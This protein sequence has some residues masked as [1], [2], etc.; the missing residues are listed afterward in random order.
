MMS[1]IC[2]Q[3]PHG[4]TS[5]CPAVS[6][7]C[8]KRW[9][10][11]PP[12]SP[13]AE[14]VSLLGFLLFGIQDW[15]PYAL[16]PALFFSSNALFFPAS[17]EINLL[18]AIAISIAA[19]AIPF[20]GGGINEIR[21]DFMCALLVAGGALRTVTGNFLKR[22]RVYQC[23]TGVFFGLAL[24]AKPTVFPSTLILQTFSLVVAI[25][26]AMLCERVT[27][28]MKLPGV[29]LRF[30]GS[31]LALASLYYITGF[32]HV[33][34]YIKSVLFSPQQKNLDARC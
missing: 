29:L 13:Y 3:V 6:S 14:G 8:L 15:A 24:L 19:C 27:L 5:I 9:F 2:S 21:P 7:D 34:T 16:T 17:G 22:S 28:R 33:F 23:V 1:R 12:H 25:A 4:F 26:A 20:T 10:A 11:N 18:V 31:S 32:S 30:F